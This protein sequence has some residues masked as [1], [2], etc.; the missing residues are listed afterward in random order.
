MNSFLKSYFPIADAAAGAFGRRCEAVVYDLTQER[1]PAVYSTRARGTEFLPEEL[2]LFRASGQEH[3]ENFVRTERDGA[4][5]RVSAS[6]LRD[7]QG[8]AAG[9]LCLYIDTALEQL[10][11]R[12]AGQFCPAEAAQASAAPQEGDILS[13]T[14]EKIRRIIGYS[15]AKTLSRAESIELVRQMEKDGIFLVKGAVDLVAEKLGISKVTVYSYLDCVK[16]RR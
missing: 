14:R 4:P 16:G 9:I 2:A 8:N 11:F 15:D 7:A 3:A 6:L 1:A 13:L 12:E 10:I 5:V